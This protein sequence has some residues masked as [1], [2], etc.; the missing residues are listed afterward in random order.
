MSR[1]PL[2]SAI[3][4]KTLAQ[5]NTELWKITRV[6]EVASVPACDIPGIIGRVNV[7]LIENGLVPVLSKNKISATK[8]RKGMRVA[9]AVCL[10]FSSWPSQKPGFTCIFAN[11]Y[12]KD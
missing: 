2:F 9:P 4:T 7:W 10:E 11:L 1:H 12:L 3:Q 6:H 8:S 5:L